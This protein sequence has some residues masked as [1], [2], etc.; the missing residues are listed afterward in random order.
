MSETHMVR[1]VGDKPGV[2][3]GFVSIRLRHLEFQ[4]LVLPC[5]QQRNQSGFTDCALEGEKDGQ[6]Q[7]VSEFS[8]Q[9]APGS[10]V[11]V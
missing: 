8:H 11:D 1:G 10:W 3:A 7:P 6:G 5:R 9:I 4:D 2:Q